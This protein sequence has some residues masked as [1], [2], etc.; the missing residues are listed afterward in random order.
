MPY[1]IVMAESELQDTISWLLLQSSMAAKH[2]LMKTSDAHDLSLMQAFTLCLLAP[3]ESVAMSSISEL[4]LCDP[5][6]VTGIVERLSVGSYIERRECATDRRVKTIT[7]TKAGTALRSEFLQQINEI[8]ADNLAQLTQAEAA[9]LKAL[10]L[11]TSAK[12]QAHK[13]YTTVQQ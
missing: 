11:K 5:S 1:N 6:N 12:P 3:G 9:T 2:R 4:L 10:L 8:D 13:T 7:L